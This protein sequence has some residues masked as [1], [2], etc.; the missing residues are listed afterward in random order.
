MT[1]LTNSR[2]TR[3]LGTC[4]IGDKDKILV[5]LTDARPIIGTMEPFATHTLYLSEQGVQEVK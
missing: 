2:L 4:K 5:H 1:E 3:K